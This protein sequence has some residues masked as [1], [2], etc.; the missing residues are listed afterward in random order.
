MNKYRYLSIILIILAAL[1]LLFFF[2]N[3]TPITQTTSPR[4]QREILREMVNTYGHD[5]EPSLSKIEPLLD[6]LSKLD[7]AAASQWSEIMSYWDYV[8]SEMKLNDVP[9]EKLA[10]N[11]SLCFVVLGY[12]LNA[13]GSMRD[14]LRGRLETAKACA[15]KYPESFLLCTGGGTAYQ[16]KQA[17]EAQVMADWLIENG[18]AP[19]RILTE[20]KSLTTTENAIFSF[21]LLHKNYPQ[22]HSVVIVTSDYHIPWGAVL[23]QTKFILEGAD[24]RVVSNAALN[25]TPTSH[26]PIAEYQRSGILSIAGLT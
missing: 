13:D 3:R 6:E 26:Y 22:I 23:F 18:I 5:T 14:E 20:A 19:D 17:T 10:P 4:S 16:N 21:D 7:D 8:N 1:L 12:Q 24:L 15:E 11:D 25:T 2:L 9:P